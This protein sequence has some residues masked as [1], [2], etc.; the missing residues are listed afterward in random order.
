MK[1]EFVGDD[2]PFVGG[3]D[4]HTERGMHP[5]R[6]AHRYADVL[7]ARPFGLVS[8][9]ASRAPH[10]RRLAVACIVIC[11]ALSVA[12]AASPSSLP[13]QAMDTPVQRE[14]IDDDVFAQWTAGMEQ[15]PDGRDASRGP[16]W[17]LWTNSRERTGH[18]G[19]SFGL[20]K[21][22][23]PRHLRIGFKEG[24]PVGTV[25]TRG[26]VRVSVLTHNAA[27]PGDVGDDTQWTSGQRLANGEV[28]TA[29]AQRDECAAW[30]LPPG[31]VTRALRFTHVAAPA[32]PNYEG[33]L[34]GA[35]I[36]RE[37]FIN[38]A[39]LAQAVSKSNNRHAERVVNGESDGW[40]CWENT[41][42]DAANTA[43]RPV[44]SATHPEWVQLTWSKPVQLSALV[45][46]WTGF[47]AADIQC[48]TGPDDLHPRDA[49]DADWRTISSP[50]GFE[51][52]YPA[53]FWP[54]VFPLDTPVTTRAIRL[55]LTAPTP[56]SHPHVM[57]KTVDGKRVWLGEVM[58]VQSPGKDECHAPDLTA[59]V[60]DVPHAPIPVHFSLPEPGYVTLV[61]ED[62]NGMRVRNLVS[63]TP[64]P[65]GDNVA[66]WDGTDDLGRDIDAANHGL[67]NIPA[68]FVGPGT[69]SVRGLWRKEIE[70]F[71]EFAVYASGNPP[72]STPDHTGAWLANHSPPEA[73]V[74]VPA[75]HSPTG[76]PTVFL[77]C[78][79]TEGP[80][81][82]AWV[83]LDGRKR[84]GM[85]WIGGNWTAAPFLARD[86]SPEAPT[87]TA[88]YV[89]SVWETDKKSGIY[90]LRVSALDK[91]GENALKTRTVHKS[92]ISPEPGEADVG[93][94]EAR[95]RSRLGGIAA[96]DGVIACTFPEQN[97]VFLVDTQ[98][99]SIAADVTIPDPGGLTYDVTGRL[100]LLSG[101][102]L[103]CIEPSDKPL[104]QAPGT[105]VVS[106]GLQ[107]P[108][109]VALD[110]NGNIY[111][112]D[113][114]DSHQV[115]VFS[116][117]GKVL[118]T[119]G[120]PGA[121]KAGPYDP[122]HMNN[123]AG[124]AVD[125][126]N[127]L[128]V[129]EHDY[130]PKRVSVW[131]LD[132]QLVKAFYG[133]GKYGGGGALDA[134]DS[135]RF[136]Y[137][138][139]T[140]GTLEFKLDWQKGTAE[141]AAVLCRNTPDSMQMP[142]RSAAPETALYRNGKRYFTNC[143]N[144]NPTSGHNTA[145]LYIE[146]NGVVYPV[147]GMGLA[148]EWDLLKTEPFRPL[149]P[150]E[151]D[152]D[153]DKWAHGRRNQALFIWTDRN[154]DAH[155]Q[156]AE[157]TMVYTQPRGV[158]VMD[159][160]SFCIASLSGR[161]T[162]LPPT[163]FTRTG[164]PLYD[165]AKAETIVDGVQG[166]KSSGGA[167]MLADRSDSSIVT[168]GVEPFSAYS[169]CG[170][171][172]GKAVW[173]YPNPW[174]GLHASHHAAKPD[175]PG[176]LIGVTRLLGGF[177]TPRDSQVG[178]LWAV[179]GNMGNLYLM[180]RDGLFV[181]T[182]FE[183][184]RQGKLWKM[185]VAER[186]MSL[187]GISLHDE[188]FWPSI[189]QTPDGQ[190]YLVDGSH[191]S[192]VRL[193]GLESLRP[194]A[195]ASVTVTPELLKASQQFVLE[196]EA[197]RQKAFGSGVLKAT[198][199]RNAPTVEGQLDDWA[200]A[201]WVEIDKRGAGANF[202]S[203]AKPYNILGTLAVAGDRL[204]AAWNTHEPKLLQNS[205]EVPNALFK[206]GGALDLMLG[207]DPKADPS[208][209]TPVAGDLRLLVT[210]VGK[211]TRAAL[212]RAIVPG[213]AEGERVPFSSPWRTVTFDRVDN[214]SDQIEL[215]TDGNGNYEVS[216]PLVLL[217]L[218]SEQGMKIAGDIGI[219]RGTGTETTV[220]SY[221]SNKATGITAD[222]PS[223]AMLTPH[224][225]GT[226]EWRK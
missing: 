127:Q 17:V 1:P 163:G 33:W 36:L 171:R 161:A 114:G 203:N 96:H 9:D 111:V 126:R 194:I 140:K 7:L 32:D 175:R 122:L 209:R 35:A 74:F 191:C 26:N 223:E 23:G 193:D 82:M 206:T 30:V 157:V 185:A 216:V 25:L 192:L 123:P 72:W 118:R 165:V 152:P 151:A 138:D 48:Y 198:I 141:V 226:I 225:W 70:A 201:E 179:N 84:G 60:S 113:R 2:R 3:E 189:S 34:G 221:W 45:A 202:N 8:R 31:T 38:V 117:E 104:D 205:G 200:D 22:A 47:G 89:A 149:W 162:R 5:A 18:S 68:R 42:M 66:W 76:E 21:E 145:F 158:T 79:V 183:D 75:S 128:W 53:A 97:R 172:E 73:A 99:G 106:D 112:S 217:G 156:P 87:S 65:A 109:A 174:P 43:S 86:T 150:A 181:A 69:Y 222:V 188:N 190:V 24:V 15:P 124:I 80:D 93:H 46:V 37:R 146:R 81:G 105:V 16:Q 133:P 142:F 120:R 103:L 213:A 144:T 210:R 154:D 147:A 204:Y 170:M 160:L 14:H 168:L 78:Y 134:H 153:G 148:N 177:V 137:A 64:F 135:T 20:A 67:Y 199:R 63:E 94:E 132:G 164:A 220:R 61:I 27:Y 184:V 102:R 95:E 169:V 224:L 85:K 115:K 91:A 130:L 6:E 155:A 166:P 129:A 28:T 182:V 52:G 71:Y 11:A 197:W 178:P 136:Y 59:T 207:T 54:N 121:P 173:S 143:Y 29:Q 195:S 186:G 212:Y 62:R 44:V 219:L 167:Q 90:E 139:E 116:P 214:V 215:A 131:S 211:E 101:T 10:K 4:A 41:S 77:G 108:V 196:R 176:Q 55:L 100:F 88:A 56:V 180:T 12:R 57:N 13:G 92:V 107:D 49:S 119:I 50:S 218:N 125:S 40:G 159:D 187:E 83:D 51:S 208:R 98:S 19:L 58:A 39:P 110:A